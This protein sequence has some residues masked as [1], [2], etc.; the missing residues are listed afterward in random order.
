V[1]DLAVSAGAT[2]VQPVQWIV[3]DLQI[4]DDKA[5]TTALEKARGLAEQ[6]AKQMGVRL[7]MLLSASNGGINE[8]ESMGRAQLKRIVTVSEQA[9][10]SLK[11]FP[12]KILRTTT[13]FVTYAIE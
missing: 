7:G 11:L 13:V 9:Q 4:L 3:T 5:A 12:Q 10:P 8:M 6:M 2:E 1:V